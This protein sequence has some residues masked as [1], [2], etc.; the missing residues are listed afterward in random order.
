MNLSEDQLE[1]LSRISSWFGTANTPDFCNKKECCPYLHAHT[2][3]CA[4]PHTHGTSHDLRP[5]GLGGLA[6][7]GKTTLVRYL[8]TALDIKIAFGTP[9]NKSAAV[10][11]GKLDEDQKTRVRTYYSLLYRPYSRFWCGQ[12][13][14]DVMELDDGGGDDDLRQFSACWDGKP[15]IAQHEC[16]VQEE[17]KF[18][19]RQ[20][21]G[22]Y[23]SLIVLD[24]ASMVSPERVE[25]IQSFGL[26]LLLVG[27]HGQLPPVKA[28][29]GLNQW[30]KRPDIV[31]TEN[32]RQG[33]ASG[34]VTAALSVRER[35]ILEHGRYGDGSTVCASAQT[36]PEILNVMD[37]VRFQP[38][39]D[40]VIICH[41]NAVRAQVNRQFHAFLSEKTNPVVGDR[42]VALQNIECV[43]VDRN[44]KG[45]WV[46][47]RGG[48][49]ADFLVAVENVYN[50]CTGTVRHLVESHRSYQRTQSLII[51]LDADSKGEPGTHVRTPVL[52]AQFG[53]EKALPLNERPHG[54]HHLWDYAYALTAHKA[55]G[56]EFDDVIV[57][58]T[59]PPDYK[60]WL[61]TAMTRAKN[62]LLVIDW[63]P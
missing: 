53:K 42:V 39:P 59:H 43:A 31:L 60:S 5:L 2:V 49:E 4:V 26:P 3:D 19:K 16:V 32:H 21:V 30:M 9:T 25:E 63:K 44:E 51:E 28:V 47:R 8:E 62:R 22:G 7:S 61:Y 11:R 1:A 46:P 27:D 23:R 24:E 34:I 48:E 35:G 37:P 6:G 38:G 40:R 54:Q 56:S 50:G 36:N 15:N 10:L 13:N 20:H 45:D 17:L 14:E 58:D 57:L 12:T 55:Q 41:T 33:E 52:L 29:G 18:G